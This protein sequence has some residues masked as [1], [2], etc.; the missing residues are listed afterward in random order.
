ML[1]KGTSGVTTDKKTKNL[2]QNKGL[3]LPFRAFGLNSFTNT[4]RLN[5]LVI[6]C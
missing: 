2:N 4:N 5:S 1:L 6:F 3:Q